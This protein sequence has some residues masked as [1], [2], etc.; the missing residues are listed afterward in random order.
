[1]TTTLEH[2]VRMNSTPSHRKIVLAQVA[3]FCFGVRRAVDLALLERSR[4]M[5]AITTIGPVV[6][7]AQVTGRLRTDGI[8]QAA[9]LD[10][11]AGGTIV[12]S[13]HGA[14]PQ[15]RER[16]SERGLKVLDVTCPFVT[17]VHRSAKQLMDQGYQ[18]LLV[19]DR[20]HT[21]VEGVVASIESCGGRIT[22]VSSAVEVD[23]L[24]L[25]S[26]V[27]VLSQ[28]TQYS[29]T[30]CDVV[31]AV[32]RRVSDVRAIN[33]VCGATEELQQAATKMARQVDVAIVIGGRN[34]ANT[35]RLREICAAE[36]IPAYQIEVAEEIDEEWFE[37]K[38]TIGLTAGAS[39]PDWIIEDVA[40]RINFGSLPEDWR[41]AHPD[42]K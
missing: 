9:K 21:E 10:D 6:H 40:R 32:C 3:G 7:N 35:R 33:T 42:E 38:R 23:L 11:V 12:I 15:L 27:G 37:G 36:Q 20:G 30:F 5:E 34:S 24:E 14:S 2:T 4:T 31:A 29:A 1:M 22:V 39:T 13:A 25:G 17:K 28:T 19:G 26:K 41:L 18:I 16:A 8:E